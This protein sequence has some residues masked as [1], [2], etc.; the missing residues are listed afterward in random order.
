M[1]VAHNLQVRLFGVRPEMAW[2]RAAVSDTEQHLGA[3]TILTSV[4]DGRHG[5]TSLHNTGCAFDIDVDHTGIP[6][7]IW[8]EE[9]RRR[10]TE[11]FDV[12]VEATHIHI[13]FQPKTSGRQAEVNHAWV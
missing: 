13:E 8:R 7:D 2:A 5:E 6:A 3:E 9:I 11:E 4:T 12:V 1:I 10:L